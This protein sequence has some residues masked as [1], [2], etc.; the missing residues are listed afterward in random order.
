MFKKSL[1]LLLG[2]LPFTTFAHSVS[3][4][5]N[6]TNLALEDTTKLAGQLRQNIR[7]VSYT[8]LTLPT[9]ELV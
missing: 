2:S 5:D 4:N 1:L 8:H 7:P 3:A 6:N 9:M